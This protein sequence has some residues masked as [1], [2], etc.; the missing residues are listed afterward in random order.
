M[1]RRELIDQIQ[2]KKSFLC[3]GLDTDI[4]KIPEHFKEC[5][6]PIF[7][8]NK[9]IIDAT[10]DYCVAYKVNTAFYEVYGERG[11]RSLYKTVCYIPR[12]ILKIADAKRGDIGNTSEMYARA[13]FK[14]LSFDAI[15]VA[16]YMGEDSVLPFFEYKDKWVIILALTSNPGSKDFQMLKTGKEYVF[17]KVIQKIKTWGSPKNTM[18]VVGATHPEM[19]QQIRAIVPDHFLLVPGIG[20]QGGDLDKIC[21]Y[22]LSKEIGLL[23]NSSRNIIYAG[24]QKK[25]YLTRATKAAYQIQ[26]D[27]AAILR[28]RKLL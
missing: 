3:I 15:T 13:F 16:P 22:G 11:W 8:F 1:T 24:S 25:D 18:L 20:A 14:A 7:E 5:S 26:R 4:T 21:E 23:V 9:E 12:N 10:K 19:L 6:D 27:M 28:R 2:A 17:E